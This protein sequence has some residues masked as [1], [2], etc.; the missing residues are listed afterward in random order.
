MEGCTHDGAASR[1]LL[2][3]SGLPPGL[4]LALSSWASA[5]GLGACGRSGGG[6]TIWRPPHPPVSAAAHAG[7]R[8]RRHAVLRVRRHALAHMGRGG[9][10]VGRAL[11]RSGSQLFA[12]CARDAEAGHAGQRSRC[13][14]ADPGGSSR[15]HCHRLF[16]L[17]GR[18]L[19]RSDLH[20]ESRTAVRR[21]RRPHPLTDNTAVSA[22]C[23]RARA[24]RPR[25]GAW[26]DKRHVVA[27]TKAGRTFE[28][29]SVAFAWSNDGGAHFEPATIIQDHSCECCRL[30]FALDGQNPIVLFR[31]IFAGSERDHAVMRF[32]GPSTPG[33][34]AR[35]PGS[36]D[37]RRVSA[38]WSKPGH[39]LRGT[40]HAVWFTDGNA[41]NGSFYA[42]ST[43]AG[44]RFRHRRHLGD[45]VRDPT[46]PYRAGRRRRGLGRLEGIR[47]LRTTVK[48]WLERHAAPRWS[49]PRVSA[50]R[51]TI[52]IIRCS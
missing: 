22:S 6:V 39:R 12:P 18:E 13:T 33:R 49:S 17:Q 47:R 45:P 7:L 5:R 36:L 11:Q 30:A 4:A 29:A 1:Q 37:H 46:R 51:R 28:G 50:P 32:T 34:P 23:A 25:P 43:D 41:R 21:S 2:A 44:Q 15:P 19:Q 38:S 40:Y 10:G 8:H 26:I 31:N 3:V 16:H 48:S 27:A 20:S 42:R 52:P 24:E 9:S 14:A 35:Q